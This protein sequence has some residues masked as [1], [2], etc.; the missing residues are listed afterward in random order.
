M[1]AAAQQLGFGK[2]PNCKSMWATGLI[3]KETKIFSLPPILFYKKKEKKKTKKPGGNNHFGLFNQTGQNLK[4]RM[5]NR[6]STSMDQRFQTPI[7][8][9]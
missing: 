3:K 7:R 1:A 6:I 8:F 5:K 4:F 2:G 9:S